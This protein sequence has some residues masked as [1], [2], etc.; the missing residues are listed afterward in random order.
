[1]VVTKQERMKTLRATIKEMD[2]KGVAKL[3]IDLCSLSSDAMD[4]AEARLQVG[5][6]PLQSYKARIETAV[7]PDPYKKQTLKIKEA[8]RAIAEYAKASDSEDGLLDLMLHFVE[9]GTEFT[10]NYGDINGKFY[11]SMITMFERF[12]EKLVKSSSEVKASF[13]ER[14]YGVVNMSGDVGWGYHEALSAL[15]DQAYP[16]HDAG[17]DR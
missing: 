15:Y 4:F 17:L 1:M 3:A 9:C 13:R 16:E 11:D 6:E 12:V 10:A 5:E 7:F 2:A 14:A 8:R